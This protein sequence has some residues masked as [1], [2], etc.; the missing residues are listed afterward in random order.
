MIKTR[1]E[2]LKIEKRFVCCERCGNE[3]GEASS[4][5]EDKMITFHDLYTPAPCSSTTQKVFA[6]YECKNELA[7][8]FKFNENVSWV[9]FKKG[10]ETI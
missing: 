10:P 6:C 1:V 4:C 2:E 7:K 3:I 9:F 5:N 8:Q